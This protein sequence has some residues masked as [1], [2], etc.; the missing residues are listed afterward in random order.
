[1]FGRSNNT[2]NNSRLSSG[3]K[4]RYSRDAKVNHH[5][6]S[7]AGIGNSNNSSANSNGNTGG[8]CCVRTSVVIFNL[9]TLVKL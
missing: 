1:M 9:I 4:G 7:L 6:H 8:M 3:S 2:A 5:Q